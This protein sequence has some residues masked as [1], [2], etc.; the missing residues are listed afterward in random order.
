[1]K[2]FGQLRTS[3]APNVMVAPLSASLALTMAYGGARSATATEMATALSI[4]AGSEQAVFDGQNALDQALDGRAASAPQGSGAPPELD[5]VNTIYGQTAY[6][7][8]SAFLDL[9]ATSYGAGVHELDFIGQPEPSRGAINAAV[10]SETHDK[11]AELLPLTSIDGSTR[12][13]L[14]NAVYLNF[15]W[16]SPFQAFLTLPGGFSRADGSKTQTQYMEQTA[17]F[18]YAED[19]NAQVVELPLAGGQLA[20]FVALPKGDLGAYEQSLLAGSAS[21]L[22]PTSTAYVDLSFPK[23]KLASP[24]VSLKTP[25]Q[26]LGMKTA[27]TLGADFSGLCSSPPNGERLFVSDV[28]QQVTMAVAESGVEASAATGVI[29][30]A[31]A[32]IGY[33]S[34]QYV[35][36]NVDHPFVVGVVDVPTGAILF[37]GHIGD[38]TR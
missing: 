31:D 37:L 38:P 23:F 26:A 10:R 20:V 8:E 24:S 32:S 35:R 21:Q 7:W 25:L 15:P 5:V 17:T 12:M 14:V 29:I 28:F 27:F 4:P 13:V 16:A 3:S 1:M 19:Q 2:L 30:D 36:M 33:P 22:V 6:P 9:L 11:I 18:P 34:P